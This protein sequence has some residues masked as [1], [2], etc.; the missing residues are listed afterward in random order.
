VHE[1]SYDPFVTGRGNETVRRN[2]EW[3]FCSNGQELVRGPSPKGLL[4]RGNLSIGRNL[5]GQ[6]AKGWCE[7]FSSPPQIGILRIFWRFSEIVA[8]EGGALRSTGG[9]RS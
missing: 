3:E 1:G 8:S 5:D 9:V 6:G 2:R 4:R 7:T